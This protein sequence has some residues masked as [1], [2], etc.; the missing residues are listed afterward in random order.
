M[1]TIVM[2]AADLVVDR[3][4]LLADVVRAERQHPVERAAAS[5]ARLRAVSTMSFR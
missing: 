2:N 1:P 4:R 3:E 5:P